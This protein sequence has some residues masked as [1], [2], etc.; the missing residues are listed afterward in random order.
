MNT[1]YN[2]DMRTL[3]EGNKFTVTV[4]FTRFKAAIVMILVA[5]VI[6]APFHLLNEANLT[7]AM[8]EKRKSI[9]SST[10]VLDIKKPIVSPYALSSESKL[11]L[12]E[13]LLY[14]LN[15]GHDKMLQKYTEVTKNK[16]DYKPFLYMIETEWRLGHWETVKIH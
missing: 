16:D 7:I 13:W 11:V 8:L 5:G 6:W 3:I 12:N 9:V 2:V 10:P 1:W 4:S 15:N 14:G